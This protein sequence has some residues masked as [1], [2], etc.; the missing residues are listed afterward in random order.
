MLRAAAGHY[1]RVAGRMR[2]DSLPA[3]ATVDDGSQ[4][5]VLC[6]A[7]LMHVAQ[8]HLF[9][10]AFNLRRVLKSGGRLLISTPLVGPSV[11]PAS[12]R[13]AQGRLFNQV[14]PENF[15][16]VLGKV[17]LRLLNRCD[18]DDS[19]GRP[20]R[21]WATR[22][23]VLEGQGSQ[24]LERIEAILNRDKKDATYKPALF[25]ALAELATTNYRAVRWLP[26]G[27]VAI[28]FSLWRNNDLWNLL[29]VSRG[30][31]ADKRD[32]ECQVKRAR[33]TL[34]GPETEPGRLHG[35]RLPVSAPD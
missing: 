21:R 15:H 13:D 19:L 27:K 8:E 1:P 7:V 33:P 35:T 31:N 32:R 14:T 22:L 26:E 10:T 2:V 18:S 34:A 5:G 12:S 9:D 23:L 30:A 17:G 6:W 4:E 16:F 29:P 3:L 20:G 11:D 28:P 25:R 24:S